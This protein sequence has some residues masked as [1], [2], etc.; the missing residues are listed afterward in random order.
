MKKTNILLTYL[1]SFTF[2]IF[3]LLFVVHICSFDVNFYTNEHNKLKLFGKSISEHIGISDD[4]LNNLTIFTLDYLNDKEESL[5]KKLII[6]GEN[7]EVYTSYEKEHMVDVKKLN[8]NSIK[9]MYICLLLSFVSLLLI[10]FKYK[11][12]TILFNSYKKTLLLFLVVFMFIGMWILIDFDSFW[13]N[14][15]HVFFS[16]NDLWILDLRKDILIMIVPPE[17]F[18][19]LVTK[20]VI[21][22]IFVIVLVYFILKILSKGKINDTRSTI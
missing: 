20:I 11:N 22:F 6:N 21:M 18:N 13:T 3:S 19:H 14:F 9:I 2:I 15:H 1:F 8:L 7:R 16:G 5:D 4:D 12:L 10:L 17:F